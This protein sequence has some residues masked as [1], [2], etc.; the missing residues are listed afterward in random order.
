MPSVI[1]Q[2]RQKDQRT[3]AEVGSKPKSDEQARLSIV[4]APIKS[5]SDAQLPKAHLHNAAPWQIIS[6]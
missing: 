3:R 2:H 6:L 4:L 1:I 5:V